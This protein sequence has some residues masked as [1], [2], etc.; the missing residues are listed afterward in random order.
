MIVESSP[1]AL[2]EHTDGTKL[3]AELSRS[4][5][6]LDAIFRFGSAEVHRWLAELGWS[7]DSGY[8]DNFK[9]K[10]VAR[11][12]EKIYQNELPLY[13]GGAHAVIGGWHLPWPDGDWDELVD[14]SLVL[15][16]FE[17]SEPWVEVWQEESG[18]RVIPRIT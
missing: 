16:T 8:N 6:P 3:Y 12:Y 4:L 2:P 11:S 10:E 13:S 9:G 17:D 14:K 15:W 5:P 7:P 18:F 1:G